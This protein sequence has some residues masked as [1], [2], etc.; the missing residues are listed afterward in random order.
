MSRKAE[1]NSIQF[2]LNLI[3]K[4]SFWCLI[5]VSLSTLYLDI[6]GQ[7]MKL[8]LCVISTSVCDRCSIITSYNDLAKNCQYWPIHPV[9]ILNLFITVIQYIH[10]FEF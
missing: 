9:D 5:H 8:K 1:S 10:I 4:T 7:N 2:S 6:V 3:V